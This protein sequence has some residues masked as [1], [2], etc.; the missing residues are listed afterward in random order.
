M[1][2]ILPNPKDAKEQLNKLRE[3]FVK[4]AV[5]EI[6]SSVT[7][8]AILGILA[9]LSTINSGELLEVFKNI[10]TSNLKNLKGDPSKVGLPAETSQFINIDETIDNIAGSYL[11]VVESLLESYKKDNARK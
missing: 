3:A 1:S 7:F 6:N 9:T 2:K 5:N 4:G 8:C 11:G 10:F